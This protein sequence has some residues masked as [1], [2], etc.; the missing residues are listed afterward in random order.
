MT[1]NPAFTKL[2]PNKVESISSGR[3]ATGA[4]WSDRGP[5]TLSV[6]LPAQTSIVNVR[7]SSPTIK[8]PPS[9]QLKTPLSPRT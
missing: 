5:S 1:S 2:A 8:A 3:P 4:A 9:S 7:S 6:K